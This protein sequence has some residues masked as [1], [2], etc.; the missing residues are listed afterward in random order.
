M[1]I[2]FKTGKKM[3]GSM[4]T[5]LISPNTIH[6]VD[7]YRDLAARFPLEKNPSRNYYTKRR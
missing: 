1:N 5:P 2:I 3:Y 4:S 7:M 6:K